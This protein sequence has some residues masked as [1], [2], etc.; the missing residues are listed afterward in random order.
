MRNFLQRW[1][2]L[3]LVMALTAASLLGGCTYKSGPKTL[4]PE[5]KAAV[6]KPMPDARSALDTAINKTIRDGRKFWFQ[7]WISSKIQK[8]KTNSMYNEGTF[9]RDR[10]FLIR[11]SLLQKQ[12]SYYRW[13]D[14]VYVSKGEMWRRA[15]NN[16]MPPD[17]FSGFRQLAAVADS[18]YQLPDEKVSG[19]LCQVL[20]LDL[21]GP[22][23]AALAPPNVNLPGQ[24]AA[25]LPAK[26][27]MRYTLWIGK[28]DNFIY[29]YRTRLTM[30]VPGAG[31]L[32]QE[33]FFKFVDYNS[34]SV[35]L[36]KP[37]KVERYLVQDED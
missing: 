30:P 29:Q 8:R 12:Y 23:I 32:T 13:Q 3:L 2:L 11:A 5:K 31:A 17:P 7:G 26:A 21:T 35:N 10:G 22:E 4:A 9:D 33:T 24:T 37:E 18:V 1:P 36:P 14:R 34:A 27:K 15:A 19:K 20:Q 16:E 28:E 25:A 6:P